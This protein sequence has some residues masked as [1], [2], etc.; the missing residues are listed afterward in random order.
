MWTELQTL[1]WRPIWLFWAQL[2]IQGCL[3]HSETTWTFWAEFLILGR[4]C[5]LGWI[6]RFGLNCHPSLNPSTSAFFRCRPAASDEKM[7]RF[8][9]YNVGY[10]PQKH[11]LF[12]KKYDF[13]NARQA[14]I[15][16]I[17]NFRENIH[18][19]ECSFACCGVNCA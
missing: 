14:M 7:P 13:C 9:S 12:V 4:I 2:V 19:A 11:R 18:L 8:R 15:H 1:G 5:H 17:D 10:T 6:W 16:M 3:P